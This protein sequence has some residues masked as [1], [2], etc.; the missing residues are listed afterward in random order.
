MSA[1]IGLSLLATST[2]VDGRRIYAAGSGHD[3]L[4]LVSTV[5]EVIALSGL[6]R[7]RVL[8]LGTATYD[9]PSAMASQTAN[10]AMLGCNVTALE[11]AWRS[12]PTTV[13]TAAFYRADI[14]LISGGNTLFAADRWA[15]LGMDVL[16]RS[17]A[18][19]GVVLSGGSA[20]F[21]SLCNGG[22]SDSME[23]DSY[24]NPPG[25]ILNGSAGAKAAV[26]ANWAYIRVPGLG[27]LDSLC[28]PHYDM[29]GSN[30]VHR[31]VDFTA[32]LAH[33]SGEY[34]IGID[35]WAA[36]IVDGDQYTLVSRDG[37]PGSVHADGSFAPDRTGKPGM[38]LLRLNATSGTLE[39][40]LAPKRGHVASLL[41]P[42]RYVVQDTQLPVAR[43]QNPDDGR[44]A[45][46]N[47]TQKQGYVYRDPYWWHYD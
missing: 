37:Y 29:V 17:A 38:W 12:P 11:V 30:G 33:H 20:G 7:P 43:G 23:P 10:F 27:V 4:G 32:M 2:V 31:A 13:L 41:L 22:H 40:T 47:S 46:W 24:K 25:P 6:A 19:R 3:M 36:L 42:P 39:R 15:T 5:K 21:I 35:N 18:D 28:C 44:P 16:M 34:A 9:E 45:A 14:I 8:Y 26:D 1:L